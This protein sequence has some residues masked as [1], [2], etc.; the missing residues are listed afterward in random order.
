M[1]RSRAITKHV[2]ISPRKVR[3]MATLIRG[4]NAEEALLQLK[5]AN[6]KGG[7]LLSKTLA[8]AMANAE[9]V[10]SAKRDALK[11]DEVRVDAGPTL[12][13]GKSKSKGGRV[14]ILK[15]TSHFTVVVRAEDN[16]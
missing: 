4:M 7:R 8:S 15:R 16:R 2:R 12:K 3:P 6:T 10:H 11:V 14:P 13:R 9:T 5:V 1:S